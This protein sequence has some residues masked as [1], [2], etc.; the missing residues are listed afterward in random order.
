MNDFWLKKDIA[1]MQ[2]SMPNSNGELSQNQAIR[3]N[4]YHQKQKLQTLKRYLFE[5]FAILQD[6]IYHLEMVSAL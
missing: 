2:V 5:K 3:S 6:R 1:V 4:R